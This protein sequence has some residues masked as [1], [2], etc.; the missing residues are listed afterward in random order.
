MSISYNTLKSS[1]VLS[2]VAVDSHT[3]MSPL[4]SATASSTQQQ[5]PP[6]QP[7]QHSI[8]TTKMGSRRIF[9]AQFKLQVLDSYRMDSD[10]KGNQRATARKYGIHRRQIQKWLQCESTLRSCVVLNNNNS[11]AS[12]N[13]SHG[14][15]SKVPTMPNGS[16][17]LHDNVNGS[18]SM[19]NPPS[20][21]AN[22][23][24]PL[25]A[26]SLDVPRP[27]VAALLQHNGSNGNG[28]VPSAG[29]PSA[30]SFVSSSHAAAFAHQQAS[31]RIVPTSF[32]MQASPASSSAAE[33]RRSSSPTPS[34]AGFA[35]YTR[36]QS[37][38]HY[39]E[40]PLMPTP[41]N[42]Y[43]PAS[44]YGF[45]EHPAYRLYPPAYLPAAVPVQPQPAAEVS[46]ARTE[47]QDVKPPVS[48]PVDLTLPARPS[49][50]AAEFVSKPRAFLPAEPKPIKAH[51]IAPRVKAE[52]GDEQK[53]WDLSRKRRHSSDDDDDDDE[54]I[55]DGVGK[56]TDAG[57]AKSSPKPAK[58]VKLF[59]PYLLSSDEE[60]EAH[61]SSSDAGK[62]CEASDSSPEPPTQPWSSRPF[63]D[64]P[65]KD[66]APPASF[67]SPPLGAST[68]PGASSYWLNHGSPV[69]G[70]DSASSTFSACS[71]C[72]CSDP[73]CASKLPSPAPT[74]A[75]AFSEDFGSAAGADEKPATKYIV[76]RRHILEKWTHEENDSFSQQYQ[77]QRLLIVG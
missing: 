26:L 77:R 31:L 68:P 9:S 8:T 34:S 39:R 43:H 27:S 2:A 74:V 69:S 72:N 63:Y 73:V 32:L 59:K 35:P 65:A 15:S 46:V 71:D 56:S 18:K 40:L 76:P 61:E 45:F 50:G 47:P 36:P 5:P 16:K 14:G 19:I 23:T 38:L 4:S 30:A 49:L 25:G 62:K 55:S 20:Q 53:P 13:N 22:S 60:E 33:Q 52:L 6:H 42:S 67:Q 57:D 24:N 28:Y 41:I 10:C 70:Y 29:H 51:D 11:S 64:S 75:S 1:K 3:S 54:G 48:A 44:V 12:N 17:R 37:L 7:S 66:A 21:T 58:V